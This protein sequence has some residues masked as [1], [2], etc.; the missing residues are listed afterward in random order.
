MCTKQHKQL[1]NK[2][3]IMAAITN[4]LDRV[5]TNSKKQNQ[6]SQILIKSLLAG[7]GGYSIYI[8]TL[9]GSF[10]L[11]SNLFKVGSSQLS[12]TALIFSSIGYLIVYSFLLIKE[13]RKNNFCR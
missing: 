3:K 4:S 9:I 12:S 13:M 1:S 5:I 6:I 10:Y 8:L 7:M 11:I 2:K